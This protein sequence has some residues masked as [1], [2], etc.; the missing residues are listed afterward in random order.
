M[1]WAPRRRVAMAKSMK[2]RTADNQAEREQL[3]RIYDALCDALS[4]FEELSDIQTTPV[5]E[6]P[7]IIRL[8]SLHMKGATSDALEDIDNLMHAAGCFQAEEKAEAAH[9]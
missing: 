9:G 6:N 8:A 3:Q 1:P 2:R 5:F 7:D 4:L